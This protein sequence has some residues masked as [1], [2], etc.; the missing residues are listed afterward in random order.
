MHTLNVS[1]GSPDWIA[2][3]RGYDCA[4]EAAAA[5]GYDKNTS[6]T[7]LMRMK[8]TGGEKEFSDWVRKNLLEKG[9][10]IEAAARPLVDAMIGDLYPQV[11][12]LGIGSLRL[13]ASFDGLTI[14]DSVVWECKSRNADLIAAIE[15][16]DLPNSHWPQVEQQLLIS[17]AEYALFTVSDGTEVGSIHFKYTSK[18]DR[19]E[20]L[21]ATW[22]QFNVDRIDY[23][24]AEI[25]PV[26]VAAPVKDLPAIVYRL[27]GLALTSNLDEY[28]SAA[29]QL[30]ED[31]KA[32]LTTDQ[33]FADRD[34]LCKKFRKAEEGIELL[35]SQVIGEI[36]DVD[37]FCRDLA[38]ISGLIRQARLAGEKK[39]AAEKENR[40]N[41]IVAGGKKEFSEYMAS[42]NVRLG[43]PY[44]PV[45]A[46]DFALAIRGLKSLDSMKNA[47]ST[48][49]AN[50]KIEANA[51][52]DKIHANLT[53]LRE[54]ANGHAFLF[55]DT[56]AIVMKENDDLISLIKSRIADHTT[57]EA[58]KAEDLRAKI[59]E[60]ERVKAE[61]KARADREDEDNLIASFHENASR[62][63]FD[64][65][66]YIQRAINTFDP[67]KKNFENDP[68]PRVVAAL[69]SAQQYMQQ[70]LAT[71]QAREIA[72]QAEREETARQASAEQAV[73]DEADRVKREAQEV[74]LKERLK[75]DAAAIGMQRPD[76]IRAAE[77]ANIPDVSTAPNLIKDIF[78]EIGIKVIDVP[79]VDSSPPITTGALC[80]KARVT[81]TAEFIQSIGFSPAE[82]PATS[83][84]G[85]YWAAE[86]VPL[87][88][89][90]LSRHFAELAV[91]EHMEKS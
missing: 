38:E 28:K 1:Q 21:L 70:R 12:V 68:R 29:L 49:L 15:A 64:K 31:S 5:M 14:D 46:A 56:S 88:F 47:V 60:E 2:A 11:G 7:D 42:L 55:S 66:Q 71:A 78:E 73:I 54:L 24:P 77:D 30:V 34:A 22:V 8:A 48:A 59:A 72:W 23:V 18:T 13:L 58:K 76:G 41:E 3:R 62:I 75:R 40:R 91:L 89:V 83:K 79:C 16:G 33:D 65:V 51:I 17:G 9:H 63:E 69:A 81:M 61:A 90:A 27:N 35:Q 45:V 53:S 39:V 26:P 25:V 44:M 37:K 19:R 82:R 85:T 80:Q 10:E 6:R 86:D 43:K 87:I 67:I 36:K 20:H 4:S 50:A 84:N 32:E 57:A 52:A 74:E